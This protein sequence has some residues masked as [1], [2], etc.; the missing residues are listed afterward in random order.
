[1]NTDIEQFEKTTL[2][3][4]ETLT[5]DFL[6]KFLDHSVQR[7]PEKIAAARRCADAVL[8]INQLKDQNRKVISK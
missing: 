6:M 4:R 5:R 8:G 1:M 3:A 7:E 2:T